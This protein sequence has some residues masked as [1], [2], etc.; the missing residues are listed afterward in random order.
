MPKV[1]WATQFSRISFSTMRYSDVAKRSAR[2]KM[3]LLVW[4]WMLAWVGGSWF[5]TLGCTVVEE[6]G[7]GVET[8]SSYEIDDDFLIDIDF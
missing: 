2:Q 1:S 7:E 6:K 4:F 5:S 3:L 8:W